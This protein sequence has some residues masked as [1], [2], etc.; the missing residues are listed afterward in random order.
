MSFFTCRLISREMG[1]L[2]PPS[3]RASC[4]Y[5][6]LAFYLSSHI[7]PKWPSDRQKICDGSKSSSP[8]CRKLCHRCRIVKIPDH[9]VSADGDEE[10]RGPISRSKCE[11]TVYY[12]MVLV[13]EKILIRIVFLPLL[14]ASNTLR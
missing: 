3:P 5:T 8:C 9:R 10:E 6:L 7:A 12:W 11:F 14:A 13:K 1:S 4:E 2:N